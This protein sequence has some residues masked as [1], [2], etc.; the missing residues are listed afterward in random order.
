MASNTHNPENGPN[1]A[2]EVTPGETPDTAG[3][4]EKYSTSSHKNNGP[5]PAYDPY[6]TNDEYSD[7]SDPGIQHPN[8]RLNGVKGS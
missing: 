8:T 2:S 4:A 7:L 1:R 6:D 5:T 3:W